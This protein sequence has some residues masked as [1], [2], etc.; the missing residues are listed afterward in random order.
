VQYRG[1]VTVYKMK[2]SV[3]TINSYKASIKAEVGPE[4]NQGVQ[5]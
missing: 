4:K 3:V 2:R 1:Y 5:E